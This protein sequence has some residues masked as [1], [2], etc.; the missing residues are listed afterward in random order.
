MSYPILFGNMAS[1]GSSGGINYY[2]DGSDGL[3]TYS[4]NTSLVMP[5]MRNNQSYNHSHV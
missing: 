2:G 3:V 5:S 1:S 4:T